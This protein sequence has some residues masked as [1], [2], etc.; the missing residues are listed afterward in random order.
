MPKLRAN[1]PFDPARWPFFYGWII[2]ICG[3]LGVVMS[4]PGQT[5]GVSVFTDPLIEVLGLS[6]DQLSIAYMLGT[7]GSSFLL[8]WAGRKYDRWGA[9]S[10][11]L[12][13][14]VGLG[15]VLL[16]LSLVDHFLFDLLALTNSLFIVIIMTIG[17]LFLRFFGQGV[18]TMTSRNMMMEW[19]DKRRGFATGFSNVFVSLAFS[20]SPVFLY[21]LIDSFSWQGAWQFMALLAG[22]LFPIFII[23][24]FRDKPEDSGLKP[25]GNYNKAAKVTKHLF[26]VVKEY[27]RKEALRSYPFWVFALMLSMQGL[28]ITGFTF[29]VISIFK[30]S[31]L[32]ETQAITIFQP[33]AVIAVIVTLTGSSISDHVPLKY[34]LY[35]LGIGGCIAISGVIFLSD[36]EIAYYMIIAGSG[37]T[38]GVFSVL[39]SVTWPRYYGRQHLGAISGQF[40]MMIV[41]GSALGPILFSTSLTYLGSYQSAGWVCFAIYGLLTL[42]ALKADNPQKRF[43]SSH[44]E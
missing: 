18:L 23:L 1:T 10:L 20:A 27:T 5:M 3:A 30:E 8:P 43:Y 41:F 22:V 21:Y 24:F 36:L 35:A 28:Y 11:A 2:L 44:E 12:T 15:C 14:S 29:H 26:P 7:I 19:F 6:R 40:T 33:S 34:L 17:F 42:A 38:T 25:D 4:V 31:G 16:F 9:R 37:I 13:S 32:S 39:T